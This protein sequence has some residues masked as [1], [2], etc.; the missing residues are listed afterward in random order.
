MP[1]V[2]LS[3]GGNGELILSGTG[4]Y[5]GGTVVTAGQLVVMN[6]E[7]LA[8]GT[9]LTVGAGG[10]AVFQLAAAA[11]SP[12]VS[13]AAS[14]VP[15]PGALVLLAVGGIGLLGFARRWRIKNG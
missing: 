6:S 7:A 4:S 14:P 5:S 9:R 11:A 2:A 12:Q 13:S 1:G 8:D 10:T 15:E 3:L